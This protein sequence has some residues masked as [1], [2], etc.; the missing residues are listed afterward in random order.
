MLRRDAQC[1]IVIPCYN[2]AERLDTWALRK[3]AATHP[4]RFLMVNDGSRDPTLAIL[5]ELR[6]AAPGRFDVLHLEQNQGKAEA[7][8]RGVLHAALAHPELIGYWDADLATPLDE[9]PQFWQRLQ[10]CP[11][12]QLVL[13]SRI[14][15]LGSRIERQ[16]WRHVLGRVFATA[17]SLAL[18]L[19]VYDTQCGAKVFRATP[20]M[21]G[22][23]AQPFRSRWVF[24]VEILAR[25][26]A[27]C[28]STD[29]PA[30]ADLV[31]EL[32]LRQWTDVAGS[33]LRLRQMLGAAL[34][35]L[36]IARELRRSRP[37]VNL[38]EAD[39]PP[40]RRAA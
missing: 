23:F 6:E 1:T 36:A 29:S 11:Q 19:P 8:R 15:L 32:P 2:E 14:R 31:C 40:T 35:L 21:L 30:V 9:L 10:R 16:P 13:G 25:L 20:T 7:V 5:D 22:L 3:F 12:I 28:R 27:V 24:D 18:D 34:S 39:E 38:S 37:P 33:K 26:T 17:A 4:C